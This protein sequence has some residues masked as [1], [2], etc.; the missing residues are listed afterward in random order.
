MIHSL[1]PQQMNMLMRVSLGREKADLVITG[2][3]LV[4]VYS[5]ELLKNQSVAVKGKWIAYV[6][7]DADHCIGPET[8]SID[9]S[10]KTLIPGL[11]DGHTHLFF[12]SALDE[13][14]RYAIRGGTT[15]IITEL[16]DITFSLGYSGI[17]EC[18]DGF[19][20]QPVKLFGTV[21]M[22]KALSK[23]ILR[24]G[25]SQE[26]LMELLER[27]EILGVG[28]GLW[29]HSIQEDPGF[30]ALAE[31]ALR[32]GKSI[33]GHAAGCRG[34]KLN[35]YLDCGVSSC[36]ESVSVEEVLEKLRLGICVMIREGGV[37]KE[38]EAIAGIK[39]MALDFRRLA[40]ASDSVDPR[41]L[42]KN[43]YM[44]FVVQRAIDL[45]FDPI[46]AIQMATLNPAEHF[47][48]D[49]VLGGIAPGKYADIVII[50]DLRLI[51][52]EYVI[53]NGQ[54]I[55]HHKELQVEP[56]KVRFSVG[57][58]EGIRVGQSDFKIPAEGKGPLKTRIIDQITELITREA[59]VDMF[60][61]DGELKTDVEQDLL[62]VSLI[63][64][65]GKIFTGFIRGLGMTGALATSYAWEAFGIVVVAA[66]EEDMARAVNRVSE[67]GGGIALY[68]DGRFLAEIPLP[69]GGMMSNL[70]IEQIARR[71]GDIQ[72]K[73]KR[74]G[75]RFGDPL[76]TL[77]T[78]TTPAIPF[79]RISEEGLVDLKKG[80]LVDLI[81]S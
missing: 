15:T 33:E 44:E 32:L 10:G 46:T 74:L 81:V 5:G 53:S 42:I 6:G 49:G 69:I 77:S 51:D 73:A 30:Q 7:P 43:G 61:I 75:F 36:H 25:P 8:R 23:G 20:D 22:F 21:P 60:P 26:Q 80:Q 54:I 14:L 67:L 12:Y 71:L 41:E 68:A 58:L 78:L 38:L 45:G 70:P 64:W 13:F 65:E 27:D 37:R 52:A 18:L 35:A 79:L 57:G 72:S 48:L 11:I 62:K 63:T 47:R 39:D 76:L 1:S 3:D 34:K 55:A 19:K 59:I 66:N 29:Q 16:V 24:R 4:N 28:E 40:F 17:L 31:K 2:G 50:P 56:R 9:A